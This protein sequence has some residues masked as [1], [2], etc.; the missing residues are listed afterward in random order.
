[1]MIITQ[2]DHSSTS[3]VGE[4]PKNLQKLTIIYMVGYHF[5]LNE[6]KIETKIEGY[7]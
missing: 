6:T 1:M 4:V 3:G 2:Q 7:F 5:E